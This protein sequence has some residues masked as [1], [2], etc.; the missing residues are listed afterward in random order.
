MDQCL[1]VFERYTSLFHVP[2]PRKSTLR[3]EPVACARHLR[4][5]HCGSTQHVPKPP[6]CPPNTGMARK[7]LRAG[8]SRAA[9]HHARTLDN[10][11][12]ARILRSAL[13]DQHTTFARLPDMVERTR[14][15]PRPNDWRLLPHRVSAFLHFHRTN[16][17]R[18]AGL[19]YS[20]RDVAARLSAELLHAVCW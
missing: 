3:V 9:H 6:A 13:T 7:Q 18:R 12:T 19:I 20:P 5:N 1:D 8:R 17:P 10:I 2:Q 16:H 14:P 11:H 15:L 4:W